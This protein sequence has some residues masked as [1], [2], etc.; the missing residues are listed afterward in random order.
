MFEMKRYIYLV[1]TM[2]IMAVANRND[3]KKYKFNFS[4]ILIDT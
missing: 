3:C 4:V 2:E 1:Y